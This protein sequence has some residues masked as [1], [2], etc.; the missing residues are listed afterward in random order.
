MSKGHHFRGPKRFVPLDAYEQDSMTP[1]DHL[2]KPQRSDMGLATI[3]EEVLPPA[4]SAM[5]A[6]KAGVLHLNES[7]QPINPR[8]IAPPPAPDPEQV[9]DETI[10]QGSRAKQ[11]FDKPQPE[12]VAEVGEAEPET[13]VEKVRLNAQRKISEQGAELAALRQQVNDILAATTG[14]KAETVQQVAPPADVAAIQKQIKEA[15]KN[16]LDD[17]EGTAEKLADLQT[18]LAHASIQPILR[19]NEERSMIEATKALVKQY[20]GLVSNRAEAAYVD[21]LAEDLARAEGLQ[22]PSLDHMEQALNSYAK[23]VG[24]TKQAAGS[25]PNA[26][27]EAMK[28]DA[29][30]APV[31][32]SNGQKSKGKI[33][34]KAELDTLLTRYPDK[35]RELQPEI[36]RAYR[37]NRVK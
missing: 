8:T 24:W 33:W 9:K 3:I 11:V 36:M 15:A 20:P 28:R 23:K 27:V 16:F 29:Q 13:E 2:A 12:E 4:S 32:A 7:G 17:P 25:Q 21:V 18:K 5:P 22:A 1:P 30:T 31:T 14:K 34:R 19:Q 35:Y 6:H 26:E 37:E 10:V